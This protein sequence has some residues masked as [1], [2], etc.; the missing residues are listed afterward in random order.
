[1]NLRASYA[2]QSD[3]GR[4]PFDYAADYWALDAGTTL[5]GFSVAAGWERLGSDNGRAV[6]TPMAT[7][8]KFNG[9]ADLFLTTPPAGLEDLY[10]SVGRRFDGIRLLPGLNAN[11]AYHR[12]ESA[13][14]SVHYGHEWDASVGFRAGPLG[15]LFKLADYDA[16]G[17]G[18]DTTKVWLQF[19][20]SL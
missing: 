19:E 15:V 11:L 9:W 5:A 20:W 3:Y 2:R 8:H 4:N 6:Q 14:G 18:A 16:S 17:F 12:F 13:A 7:L 10:V 1:V